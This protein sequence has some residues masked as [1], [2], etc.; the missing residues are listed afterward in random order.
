LSHFWILDVD[1]DEADDTDSGKFSLSQWLSHENAEFILLLSCMT[2]LSCSAVWDS[3]LVM[4]HASDQVIFIEFD[5]V[6]ILL[7]ATV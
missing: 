4:R 5:A 3:I 6:K 2:S 7:Y 1:L